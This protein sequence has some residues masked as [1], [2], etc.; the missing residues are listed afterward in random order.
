MNDLLAARS[1]MAL[2]LAFH[3]L[4][5]CVGIAMPLLMVLAEW[6]W[7]RTRDPLWLELCKRWSKGTAILFAIGAVSGTVLSFQ[8]G[9]LWPGFMAKAGPVI[10]L[11]FALEGFAFFLEAI[12]LGLYLYGWKRLGPRTHLLAGIG[13]L[14]AGAASG[15][16]VVAANGW[17]NQPTGFRLEDGRFVDIDPVAAMCNVMW[18]PQATHMLLAAFVAVGFGAAGVHALLLLRQP[19]DLLHRR[20][21]AVALWVGGVAAV[22][23]PLS[24]DLLAQRVA[25]T[26]PV[27]LAAM[28]GLFQ[29]AAPAPLS[30][31]GWPDQEAAVTRYAI[32]L[33]GMLSFLAF[34]DFGARVQGLEE[35]PRELWPPV[36]ITHVAFQV[37]VAIGSLLVLVAAIAAW[38]AWR[39][40]SAPTPRWFL[41][42]LVACAPLGFVAVEAG[43]VVTEVGRQPWI[44]QG[45][46]RTAD[47]VTPVG[48]LVVP[49][50][51]FAAL[52]LVLFAVVWR[53][54]RRHVFSSMER[55]H[56]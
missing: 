22:L 5:A 15:V 55:D 36:A 48:P 44:V 12:C 19:N 50:F 51:G 26:Q 3:I 16:F 32:E 6:R 39:R 40:R 9:L 18:L 23:V 13:V 1:L 33:P 27:K 14:L 56:V 38:R 34:G 53:L 28:E 35:F 46:M 52:Y 7:L 2:S 4:F 29:S 17:M 30:I 43:W 47:A 31:G 21:L 11:P 24:G 37:M 49:L 41:R 45:V 25:A 10:G 20:A 8:L 54:L 42:L